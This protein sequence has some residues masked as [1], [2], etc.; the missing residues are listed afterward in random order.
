MSFISDLFGGD[1][2]GWEAIPSTAEQNQARQFLVQLLN[3]RLNFPTRQVAGASPYQTQALD[4]LGRFMSTAP[5]GYEAGIG[6]LEKTVAGGYNPV[7]SPE[8]SAYRDESKFNEEQEVN[9]LRRSQEIQGVMP[10]TPALKQEWL[11]RTPYASQREGFLASLMDRER[12]RQLG[13][14]GPLIEAGTNV[15]LTQINAGMTLGNLPREITQAENDALFESLM[16]TL[17]GPYTYQ[18]PVASSITG[19]QRYAYQQ[20]TES[21]LSGILGSALGAFAGSGGLGALAT[22]VDIGGM[23]SLAYI[24]AGL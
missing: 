13:A 10:G 20:P 14:V 21:P 16:Q 3:N 5:R 12:S 23:G 19:E 15:P 8:Y 24:M 22:G 17:L 6:E 18:A 7:T 9:A 11:S 4:Q 1:E 2:G